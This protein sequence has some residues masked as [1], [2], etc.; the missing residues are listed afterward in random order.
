MPNYQVKLGFGLHLGYSIEGAIGSTFKI[1][2]SYLSPHVNEANK[3]EEKTKT[4]GVS[5]VISNDFVDYLSVDARKVVRPIDV[6]ESSGGH[7]KRKLLFNPLGLYTV[8][9]DL[10][11]LQIED[12]D[13]DL[14]ANKEEEN[15]HKKFIKVRDDY[16]I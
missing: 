9:F 14:D 1:D 2:A 3:L 10:A 12:K 16:N 5:L 15:L 4:Y 13:P 6:I 11:P 8:D 7:I